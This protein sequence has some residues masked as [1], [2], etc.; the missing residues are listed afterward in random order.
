MTHAEPL[1]CPASPT[2]K[3]TSLSICESSPMLRKFSHSTLTEAA[4][5]L[6]S[7]TVDK[8][9]TRLPPA[10]RWMSS[11]H[12]RTLLFSERSVQ[13]IITFN[14]GKARGPLNVRKKG[15]VISS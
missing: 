8:T 14:F 13:G 10:N 4:A 15:A 9:P 5:H 6:A 3:A 7:S 11:R 1:L 12:S 2:A